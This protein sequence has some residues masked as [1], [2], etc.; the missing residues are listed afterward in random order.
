MGQRRRRRR[1]A[2]QQ[3]GRAIPADG[4]YSEDAALADPTACERTGDQPGVCWKYW[5]RVGDE[6]RVWTTY[7]GIPCVLIASLTGERTRL[8]CDGR[9][10]TRCRRPGK[11]SGEE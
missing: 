11:R 6:V 5:L 8:N 7:R 2:R 4:S 3:V 1:R 10:A 9:T